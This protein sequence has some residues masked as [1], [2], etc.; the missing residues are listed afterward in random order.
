[1]SGRD[2][3]YEKAAVAERRVGT[4]R[5]VSNGMRS[6]ETPVLCRMC[7]DR[8]LVQVGNQEYVCVGDA[9]HVESVAAVVMRRGM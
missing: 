1:M 4:N 5:G 6:V 8:M 7:G 2:D 3:N 9:T